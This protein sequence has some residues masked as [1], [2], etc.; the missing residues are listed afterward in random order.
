MIMHPV[1]TGTETRASVGRVAMASSAILALSL[2]TIGASGE[3]Q[4]SEYA[5]GQT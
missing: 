1:I 4:E 5:R 2:G 3:V